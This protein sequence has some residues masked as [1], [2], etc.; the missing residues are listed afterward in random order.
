VQNILKST[1]RSVDQV[2]IE[3]DG[4]WTQHAKAASPANVNAGDDDDLV[5]IKDSR[6]TA[7]KQGNTPTPSLSSIR[8]PQTAS[9]EPSTSRT[10]SQI[11]T[12][13]KRPISQVIDL[14]LSDDDDDNPP[15]APKRQF[16]ASMYG[17]PPSM[18]PGRAG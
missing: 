11:S 13:G 5:E 9:R 17:T 12:N 8:T 10:T 4:T 14:T 7:L 1:S 3:P 16:G 18:F 15:R 2:T 6:V